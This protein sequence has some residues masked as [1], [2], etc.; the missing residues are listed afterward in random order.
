MCTVS[1][2]IL[3]VNAYVMHRHPDLWKKPDD[4]VPDRFLDGGDG[5][6]NSKFL[7]FSPGPRRY[8]AILEAK[9]GFS[10][11]GTLYDLKCD[12]PHE[13]A[14]YNLINVPKIGKNWCEG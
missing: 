9:V 3:V 8:F 14:A 4:F 11:L 5:E 10:S 6:I 2:A 7:R 1:V 13:Q 12:D